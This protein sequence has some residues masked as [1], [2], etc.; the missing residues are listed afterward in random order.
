MRKKFLMP[1]MVLPFLVTGCMS[2]DKPSAQIDAPPPEV[3]K[4]MEAAS[5]VLGD[6]VGKKS[7]ATKKT[8]K[9]SEIYYLTDTGYVVPFSIA[10][11]VKHAKDALTY[12]VGETSKDFVP[13]GF[14]GALPKGTKINS[15]KV[16]SGVATID[17]SKEFTKYDPKQEAQILS[18]ITWTATNYDKT[19]SVNIK[20][21]GK[22]YQP[23][24]KVKTQGLTR[25]D[26]INIEVAKGVDITGSM[27]VTLYFMAQAEDQTVFY[28]PVT[29]IIN[30]S[31]NVAKAVL[32]ELAK[33]PE[34]ESKLMGALDSTMEIHTVQLKGDTITADV[35]EQILQ[36]S[37]QKTA[38]KN[39]FDTIVLSLTE[40][41]TAKKVKVIVNGK[42]SV[43]VMTKGEKMGDT[44]V[45][46]PE[47]INSISM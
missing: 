9:G 39:V 19:K 28:V 35:G 40:N 43:G 23:K 42:D 46:R 26:G 16:N 12:L 36:Y 1:A 32:Q 34:Q 27:P 8:S 5:T 3:V 33:G 25:N 45:T 47:Q 30:R 13:E 44:P 18:A 11:E 15:V 29:R 21:D 14:Q 2:S 20:V 31:D 6:Q 41:T 10:K 24:S 17:F 7:E 38:S 37:T 4:K 22:V